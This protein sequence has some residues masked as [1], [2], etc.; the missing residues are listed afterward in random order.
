[1]VLDI[2]KVSNPADE[3]ILR[4]K[5]INIATFDQE[6]HDFCQNM[7]ETMFA[8][9][10]VGLAAPQVGRNLNIF[11]M[12]TVEGLR[13]DTREHVILVNPKTSVMG[14][15]SYKDQ[16][17]CLSIPGVWGDVWRQK[18]V[19]GEYQDTTGKLVSSV[20]AGFQARIYQHEF[21][22]LVGKLFTDRASKIVKK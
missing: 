6:I 22:H 9:N 5:S 19:V 15:G 16:E 3:K 7:V 1:M 17:G 14:G 21:D 18:E 10:G 13:G 2:L 8:S 12:R 20:F 4:K 11:V